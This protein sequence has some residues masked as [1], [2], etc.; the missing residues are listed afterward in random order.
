MAMASPEI[1]PNSIEKGYD[2]RYSA[3]V[4]IYAL[5]NVTEVVDHQH[6]EHHDGQDTG[7]SS[8]CVDDLL[9]VEVEIVLHVCLLK[10]EWIDDK[11]LATR[12]GYNRHIILLINLSVKM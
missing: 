10:A 9:G 11:I 12:S 5:A 6:R 1:S 7:S 2:D 4:E 3:D 8:C